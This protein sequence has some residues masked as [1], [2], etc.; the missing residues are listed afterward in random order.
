[1]KDN[2][3]LSGVIGAI[4]VNAVTVEKWVGIICSAAMALTY[5]GIQIYRLIRDRDSDKGANNG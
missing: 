1:M 2:G 5:C 3:L 4:A